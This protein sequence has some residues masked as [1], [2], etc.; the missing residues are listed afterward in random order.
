MGIFCPRLWLPGLL[1]SFANTPQTKAQDDPKARE[2]IHKA[3]EKLRGNTSEAV[4]S[5]RIVRPKWSREMK[6]KT[7]S[8]GKKH[9]LILITSP[10]KEQGIVYLRREKEVWNWVPSIERVVKLPPSMMSQSWMGTDFTNDDLVKEASAEDDYTHRLLGQDSLSGMPC[11]RIEM[12]PIPGKAVVWGKVMVWVDMQWYVQLRAEF[13]DEENKLVNTMYAS[14]LK[15]MGGRMLASVMEM[16]P[17]DKP[18]NK[19][20]LVYES[21]RFDHEIPDVF[22]APEQIRNVR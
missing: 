13:Y 4:V 7:W 19:T 3:E 12:K 16:I 8:K 1:F 14:S 18:G 11:Y 9:A 17:A 22:F 20:V 15:M 2:I 5:I 21:I 10:A 6:A